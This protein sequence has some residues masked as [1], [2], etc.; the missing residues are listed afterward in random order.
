MKRVPDQ[1]ALAAVGRAGSVAEAADVGNHEATIGC[2]HLMEWLSERQGAMWKWTRKDENRPAPIPSAVLPVHS[3]PSEESVQAVPGLQS[4]ESF[5]PDVTHIGKSIM[6]KGDVSGGGSVYWDGEL[7]GSVELLDGAFTVGPEGR[8]RANLQAH[9]IVVEGRVDGDL[10]GFERTELKKSAIVVGDIH[11][12]R[13][14]IEDGASL[15]GS[16][17]VHQD[18]SRRT[19]KEDLTT[20]K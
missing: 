17:Q 20:A 14:A 10:L 13:I 9:S 18:L 19:K 16:V 4:L 7:E 15:E 1:G 6:I 5:R 2:E 11:T 8:I 12:T 3:I